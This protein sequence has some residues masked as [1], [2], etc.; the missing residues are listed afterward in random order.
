[1][2]FKNEIINIIESENLNRDKLL[3]KIDDLKLKKYKKIIVLKSY[4]IN[5]YKDENGITAYMDDENQKLCTNLNIMLDSIYSELLK[6]YSD[7]IQT[8]DLPLFALWNAKTLNNT[9]TQLYTG[10]SYDEIIKVLKNAIMLV[11]D[12]YYIPDFKI[13]SAIKG[14]IIKS[15]I[16]IKFNSFFEYCFYLLR[17]GEVVEK[18]DWKRVKTHSFKIKES[19]TY[20][21][22]G[23]VRFGKNRKKV[24]SKIYNYISDSSENEFNNFINNGVKSDLNLASKPDLF[25]YQKPFASFAVVV[26]DYE[27]DNINKLSNNY[28]EIHKDLN[29][30]K[31]NT[32]NQNVYFI[33]NVEPKKINNSLIWFSGMAIANNKLIVGQDDIL[34]STDVSQ[35]YSGTGEY[36]LIKMDNELNIY[37]D[38]FGKNLI[39]NYIG[40]NIKVVSNSYHLIIEVLK[41]LNVGLYMDYNNTI[42]TLSTFVMEPFGGKFTLNMNI[43]NIKQTPNYY[44]INIANNNINFIKNKIYKDIN[45]KE[46]YFSINYNK[47]IDNA[48]NEII[49]N[50]KACLSSNHYKNFILDLS[51]GKDSRVI[52]SAFTQA[53]KDENVFVN[54]R[55]VSK[56]ND[57][58]VALKINSLYNIPYSTVGKELCLD[59]SVKINSMHRSYYMGIYFRRDSRLD[60]N[61]ITTKYIGD[62][63]IFIGSYGEVIARNQ[64][65]IYFAN[66]YNDT[67]NNNMDI[68]GFVD[69]QILSSNSMFFIYDNDV[70]KNVLIDAFNNS[71]GNSLYNKLQ[72]IHMQN[73]E[74]I[75]FSSVFRSY[76]QAEE[77]GAMHSKS[78]YKANQC[79]PIN[80]VFPKAQFDVINAL[81]PKVGAME[82][83]NLID[84]E[85][86]KDNIKSIINAEKNFDYSFNLDEMKAKWEQ[87][88]KVAVKNRIVKNGNLGD[89]KFG[90]N[91][92]L[93]NETLKALHS[94]ITIDNEI[95]NIIGIYLYEY[96]K[97]NKDKPF[98]LREIYSK[99]VS[100]LDQINIIK[101]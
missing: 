99:L 93:Y 79:L 41:K 38:Y 84:R 96:I 85:N 94:L 89:V 20:S 35:L 90:T 32:N 66:D 6:K 17:H 11:V 53:K 72:N 15:K 59:D 37:R 69:H 70:Y 61:T 39:F 33:S 48:K 67:F 28:K 77:F 54:T 25:V 16:E 74:F 12:K 98:V 58:D 21:V 4:F 65:P 57:L 18:T 81:N 71:I 45:Q 40:D 100:V 27:N 19:G 9:N 31:I 30:S 10:D 42:A 13:K 83:E 82:Y 55:F 86:Y 56:T 22:T 24:S 101:S 73:M 8:I 34:E 36:T 80:T 92:H 44:N 46:N 23:Y 5:R 26:S 51:G 29:F 43:D 97:Y 49:D 76:I 14:N 64:I 3:K 95:K 62:T 2:Y 75:H 60:S 7:K 52:Y 87:A 91:N 47:L 68:S 88:N 1:M 50:V 78:L 63:L